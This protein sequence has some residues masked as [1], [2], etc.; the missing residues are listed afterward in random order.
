M[1]PVL[2]PFPLR[3]AEQQIANATTYA[4]WA[5]AAQMHDQVSGKANWKKEEQTSMYAHQVIRSR[6]ESLRKC[7][8]NGDDKGLL[9]L[10][11]EG[12]HGNI[13]GIGDGALY[14]VAKFGTK[15][16][17]NEYID[18]I[19]SSLQY[20]GKLDNPDITFEEKLDFFHRASHCF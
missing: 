18:E 6:L 2:K 4:E 7:R 19:A 20:L 8:S 9:F 16:L 13:G 3:Q 1:I 17:I 11:N 14:S 5:E 12:I 15:N 10:L